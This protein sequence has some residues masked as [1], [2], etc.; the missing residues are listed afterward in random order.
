MLCLILVISAH[1]MNFNI[2]LLDIFGEY[3]KQLPINI[4]ISSA[5]NIPSLSNSLSNS[6]SKNIF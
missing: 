4:S 5:V 3:A 6:L 1:L 2:F